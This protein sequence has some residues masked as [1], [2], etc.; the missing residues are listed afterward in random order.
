MFFNPFVA[1]TA[2]FEYKRL[3]G[4][5]K[6]ISLFDDKRGAKLNK[7]AYSARR[8]PVSLIHCTLYIGIIIY[9]DIQVFE[10]GYLG[11]S[12][13]EM[14]KIISTLAVQ[15]STIKYNFDFVEHICI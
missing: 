12:C 3:A 13:S 7:E 9:K 6:M 4:T 1:S 8:P 2:P 15:L 11:S 5:D 10:F 14:F